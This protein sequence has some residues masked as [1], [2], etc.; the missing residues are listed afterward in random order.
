MHMQVI[1]Q[2]T[3]LEY[4]EKYS[5]VREQLLAWYADAE[6]SVWTKPNDIREKYGRRVDFPGGKIA[7]FDIKGIHYRL[8]VR[9]EYKFKL[10]YIRWFGTHAEYNK[11]DVTKV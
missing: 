4:C 7:I 9:I 8:V 2:K 6:S 1:N 5:D 11:I 3:L 10:V